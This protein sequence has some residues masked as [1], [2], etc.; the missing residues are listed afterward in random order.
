MRYNV[1]NVRYDVI[2]DDI[3]KKIKILNSESRKLNILGFT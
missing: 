3:V 2:Q 1:K